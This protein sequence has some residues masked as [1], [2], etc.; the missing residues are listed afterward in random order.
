MPRS[1]LI[2]I[3]VI[4]VV[5]TISF[6]AVAY[7][8]VREQ[9]TTAATVQELKEFLAHIEKEGAAKA[10]GLEAQI[11]RLEG[12]NLALADRISR[13]GHGF[14]LVEDVD[15]TIVID[16]RY[17]TPDNFTGQ[18]V[19]PRAVAILRPETA[20]KLAAANAEFRELGYTLKVWDAYRPAW[21]ERELW[22]ATSAKA[23]VA[24]PRYP[25]RHNRGT[26]VDVT[27]VDDDGN[28]LAMPTPFDEFSERAGRN[29]L[30]MAAGA[31]ENMDLLTQVMV[32]HGF[33]T[34]G[35]EWWHFDD[36]QWRDYP[37]VDISFELFLDQ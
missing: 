30:D 22:H 37:A 36:A 25:S 3:L 33:S 10:Q 6:G 19:Y 12:E 16:L 9:R 27:L 14:V 31:R 1:V 24:D 7:T 21:A 4:A 18:Q 13:A 23:Y 34:I 8:A 2:S 15:P 32:R 17:S 29:Y 20:A 5:L 28:E 11:S 26:T 35:N